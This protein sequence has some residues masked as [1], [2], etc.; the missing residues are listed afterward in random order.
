MCEILG[1]IS[2]LRSK[3]EYPKI[4][5]KV[6]KSCEVPVSKCRL[7]TPKKKDRKTLVSF[8]ALL[9]GVKSA[10]RLDPRTSQSSNLCGI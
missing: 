4:V 8:P 6:V 3:G 7:F 10:Q 2:P 9:T 5:N 1:W